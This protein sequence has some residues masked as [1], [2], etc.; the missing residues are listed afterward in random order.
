MKELRSLY[1]QN[2]F[3]QTPVNVATCILTSEIERELGNQKIYNLW[4][5]ETFETTLIVQIDKYIASLCIYECVKF[6]LKIL[7]FF[8]QFS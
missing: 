7:P 6:G 2:P 8:T 5:D 1:Q 4:K 3:F